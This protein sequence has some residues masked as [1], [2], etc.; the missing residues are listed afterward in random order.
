MMAARRV[1]V[2]GAG[3]NLAEQHEV[4]VADQLEQR[5]PDSRRAR[6]NDGDGVER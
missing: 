1:E 5:P 6:R 4:G 3:Q 2:A